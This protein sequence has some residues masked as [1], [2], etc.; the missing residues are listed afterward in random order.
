[1]A[2][3]SDLA[4]WLAY[5]QL[6]HPQAI[7][8]GLERVR[9]VAQR[10]GLS[11]PAPLVITVAGTNGK[12]STAAML[13]ALL[14]SA[15][16]AV[17][18][19]TSPHLLSYR[20]RVRVRGALASESALVH[21]FEQ[22]EHARGHETLTFFEYG[23]L[24]ALL[25]FAQSKLDAVVLEV[26]LGGR[27]DATN[28]VDADAVVL[29]TVGLD[30][31][32]YLGDTRALIGVEK[33]GVFRPG[34]LAVYADRE[35][36]PSV[37][38]VAE[39]LGTQLILPEHDYRYAHGHGHWRWQWQQETPIE[40]PQLALRAPRQYDNAAAALALLRALSERNND[41]RLAL[42]DPR[43]APAQM[44]AALAA[45]R[46]PGRLQLL[47]RAP[48]LWID[49]AHNPQAAESLA[50][51]LQEQP[52]A[53]RT[54]VV[55]GALADKDALGVASALRGMI[56]HWFI[57]G[58]DSINPRGLSAAALLERVV[59]GLDAPFSL[60]DEVA[61]AIS[62]AQAQAQA[63]DRIVIFGSFFLIAA[64][65]SALGYQELPEP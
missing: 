16:L 56:R 50:E 34:Q 48:E 54:L 53:G 8:L 22:I 30:H 12:G 5:Q 29:T 3:P 25:I 27:L 31:Q 65:L 39:R 21:A 10:L 23:T 55:Y 32:D 20:E 14:A 4:G 1:M 62:A 35:P 51:F 17:G 44:A 52:R 64:A 9:A 61:G 59:T 37:L 57:A 11:K 2:L 46:V 33:A 28:I 7:A 40:L 43:V 6:L 26:G 47:S 36:E 13:S 45:V 15:G 42:L 18:C 58:L 24:A 38:E 60:H 49:V 19:Y 63:S 41:Q